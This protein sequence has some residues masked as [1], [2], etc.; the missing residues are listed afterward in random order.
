LG[1]GCLDDHEEYDL[2]FLYAVQVGEWALTEQEG[3]EMREYLPRGG[4]FMADDFHGNAEYAEFVMR[5][6]FAFPDRTL[7]RL[8]IFWLPE[9]GRNCGPCRRLRQVLRSIAKRIYLM[10]RYTSYGLEAVYYD[11]GFVCEP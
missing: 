4:F 1:E 6:K 8:N 10:K 9:P 7:W 11:A 3:R 2:P 5:I